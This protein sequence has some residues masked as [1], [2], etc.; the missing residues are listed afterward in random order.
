MWLYI[1]ELKCLISNQ[2]II[3]CHIFLHFAACTVCC[4]ACMFLQG[5]LLLLPCRRNASHQHQQCTSDQQFEMSPPVYDIKNHWTVTH[6]KVCS[7][8]K[9]NL[10]ALACVAMSMALWALVKWEED[11]RFIVVLAA[12]VAFRVP[13]TSIVQRPATNGLCR[14]TKRSAKYK[15]VM[16]DVS[17]EFGIY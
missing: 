12:W 8:T 11:G 3:H 17:Q 13:L 4:V 15:V 10:Q 9:V 1:K 2:I 5:Q 14:W 7:N 16:L 6:P